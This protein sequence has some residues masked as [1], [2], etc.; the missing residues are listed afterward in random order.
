MRDG[1]DVIFL[2]DIHGLKPTG[3]RPGEKYYWPNLTRSSLHILSNSNDVRQ[4]QLADRI[5]EEIRIKNELKR[6]AK[7]LPPEY[8]P[9]LWSIIKRMNEGRL[10]LGDKNETRIIIVSNEEHATLFNFAKFKQEDI[11]KLMN[12]AE[13]AVASTLKE[14]GLA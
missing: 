12:A 5:N 2:I 14:L 10:R 3:M 9:L 6:L 1:F 8:S 7:C 4:F 11:L 13:G